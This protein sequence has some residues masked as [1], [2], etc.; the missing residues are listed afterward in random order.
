MNL[1]KAVPPAFV[2]KMMFVES[3]VEESAL[4][5]SL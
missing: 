2:P 1:V 4:T 5:S 3:V